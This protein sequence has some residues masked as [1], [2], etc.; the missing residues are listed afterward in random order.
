MS[1]SILV[2]RHGLSEAN[3]RDNIG[4]LAFAAED[5]PLM[6]QGHNQAI[7][8]RDVLLG[9]YHTVP[10]VTPAAT[11]ELL[12]T[13]QTAKDAGFCITQAYAQLDEV[14]HGMDLGELR[15]MLDYGQLPRIAL[16]AAAQTLQE[17]PA[18]AVWFTHGLRIA[19]LCALLGVY[20]DQ[21]L[22]PPFL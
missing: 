14:K 4:S 22:I 20:Q 12:R 6:E 18:E 17:R 3:N 5:A 7:Q 9:T 16:E 2:I 19:G 11:S 1:M 15:T 21:R 13:K 8:L 10:E